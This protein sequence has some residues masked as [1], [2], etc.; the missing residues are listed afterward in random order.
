MLHH[1]E[2]VVLLFEDSYESASIFPA[3]GTWREAKFFFA[4]RHSLGTPLLLRVIT[5]VDVTMLMRIPRASSRG[6][7]QPCIFL[8]IIECGSA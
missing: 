2:Y 8:I 3:Y 4:S 6:Y 1:D 5:Y 7:L